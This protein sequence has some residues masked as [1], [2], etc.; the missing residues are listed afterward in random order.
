MRESSSDL[1][2]CI[3]VESKERRGSMANSD[4]HCH[5]RRGGGLEGV[6]ALGEGGCGQCGDDRRCPARMGK[7]VVTRHLNL[8][9]KRA[10]VQR[11]F[12]TGHER[13]EKKM[14]FHPRQLIMQPNRVKSSSSANAHM[15]GIDPS[16][17]VGTL[18]KRRCAMHAAAKSRVAGG[19]VH[20]PY[21]KRKS[22]WIHGGP[23][24][25]Q[26]GN[27]RRRSTS[28]RQRRLDI[29]VFQDSGGWTP[30]IWAAEHRHIDV[31]RALLNRGADVTLR[32][33]EMNVCLHWASFSGCAEIAE[34]VLNAGC[35]LTSINQHGDT[36]LHIAAREGYIDCVTLFLSRGADI[37]IMNKEG[38]TPL[39][40]ARCDTPVWVALQ[41][42]R[43]LRRGI[44]NRIVRTERI[45]C[46]DVA[47]GYENVPIPCVNGV[48]DEGCPSD[49]KYIAENC[50]TSTMN[51]DRNITHLQVPLHTQNTHLTQHSAALG[52]VR[53]LMQ[54][55]IYLFKNSIKSVIF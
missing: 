35:P 17:Q 54:G 12:H 52:S 39:S 50:E 28:N 2:G 38:D 36:P 22:D 40:L 47:Q 33:K 25:C 8:E 13:R 14:R 7:T 19:S 6:V 24:S 3:V 53:F 51:I 30:I 26:R 5:S 49:Y 42:N 34:L 48:D 46:S 23:P 10:G 27:L 41:I 45:I 4:S 44:S 43:K 20:A 32:D 31:I 37:D 55:C 9:T 11:A 21:R 16:Y 18:E 29:S 15:E 1:Q